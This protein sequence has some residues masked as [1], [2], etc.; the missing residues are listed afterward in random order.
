MKT[1]LT[2]LLDQLSARP[3]FVEEIHLNGQDEDAPLTLTAEQIAIIRQGQ[4]DIKAG[5]GIPL[6]QAKAN[7]AAHREAWLR[8]N[9]R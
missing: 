2:K 9:P 3:E 1:K 8:A 6:D 4:A 7:L 5:K